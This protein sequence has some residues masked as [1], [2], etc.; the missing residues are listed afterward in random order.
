MKIIDEI[1][2]DEPTIVILNGEEVEVFGHVQIVAAETIE[3]K[4]D[5]E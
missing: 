1:I 2:T 5:P 3:P 4:P